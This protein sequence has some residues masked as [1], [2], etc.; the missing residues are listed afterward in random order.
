[1][2][3]NPI[4]EALQ[5]LDEEISFEEADLQVSLI[6]IEQLKS[7]ILLDQ[8]TKSNYIKTLEEKVVS[9]KIR[10]MEIKAKKALITIA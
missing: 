10:I 8:K 1:M 5:I 3:L 7:E 2:T 6:R 9:S 4:L